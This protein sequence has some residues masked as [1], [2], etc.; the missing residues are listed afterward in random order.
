MKGQG[1]KACCYDLVGDSCVLHKEEHP[2]LLKLPH[3]LYVILYYIISPILQPV[4]QWVWNG[5]QLI[6]ADQLWPNVKFVGGA[7]KSG[8]KSHNSSV[9][10]THKHV[11]KVCILFFAL[12]RLQQSL[13][14]RST[15]WLWSSTPCSVSAAAA[16]KLQDRCSSGSYM[17]VTNLCF[18]DRG[19]SPYT[20]IM[21]WAHLISYL[22]IRV[23]ALWN[24]KENIIWWADSQDFP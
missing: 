24:P 10:A 18:N 9:K 3:L 22:L 5:P 20:S 2:A 23:K 13:F 8:I 7:L 14:P 21:S 17:Y 16:T 15:G 11:C 6:L 12:L 1:L 19:W 4:L